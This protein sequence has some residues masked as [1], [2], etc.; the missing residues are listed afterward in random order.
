MQ[1]ACAVIQLIS[2]KAF[3]WLGHLPVLNWSLVQL[4]EV[5]GLSS[6]ICCALPD[7]VKQAKNMLAKHDIEVQ[8]IPVGI[9]RN[10]EKKFDDWLC[11]AS[12]PCADADVIAVLQPTAPFL[13]AGKIEACVARVRR[14]LADYSGTVMPVQV[15]Q[16]PGPSEAYAT[17]NS[18]R[19]FSPQRIKEKGF[20][21]YPVRV[22]LIESLDVT[23]PDNHRLAALMVQH[24]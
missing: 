8:A 3:N 11:S 4:Q 20:K 9:G 6:I 13:P 18:C 23:D 12:G 14:K 15:H 10:N 7:L 16:P 21:F 17:I 24:S 5:R 22:S 1:K 2:S 19:V